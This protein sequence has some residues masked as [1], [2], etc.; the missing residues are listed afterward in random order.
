MRPIIDPTLS[1]SIPLI[2]RATLNRRDTQ[3]TLSHPL[4]PA[5][6]PRQNLQGSSPF[7]QSINPR[8]APAV[9][10][11]VHHPRTTT[12]ADVSQPNLKLYI[13]GK[14]VEAP[15]S[16]PVIDPATEEVIVHAPSGEL[17]ISASGLD[18]S[19]PP[20]PGSRWTENES[21]SHFPLRLT[22]HTTHT[23]T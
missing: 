9:P 10:S 18:R 16:L 17:R 4:L 15:L 23:H 5:H 20:K 19:I 1:T 6:D 13:G 12:M 8:R 14:F 3:R 22:T 11:V 21:T 2:D 7:Q